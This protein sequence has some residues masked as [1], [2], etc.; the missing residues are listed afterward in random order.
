MDNIKILE[1]STKITGY[2]DKEAD[3]LYLSLGEPRDAIAVDISDSVL[4]RY[5]EESQTLVGITLIGL[6]QRILKE[7]N[8]KLY[9]A[10]HTEGW[11]VTEE[12]VESSKRV[13]STH[14]SLD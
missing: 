10:P 1:Y 14:W 11:V 9:V 13:F 4:A 7:L 5:N 3:V 6:K 2:Y 8:H 12:T